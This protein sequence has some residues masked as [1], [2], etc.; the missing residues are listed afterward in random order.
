MDSIARGLQ[1]LLRKQGMWGGAGATE[2]R[3]G[4]K[5]G[6]REAC[7]GSCGS[8]ENISHSFAPRAV[9]VFTNTLRHSNTFDMPVPCL[10]HPL[11]FTRGVV[12]SSKPATN[13]KGK[14]KKVQRI[15]LIL[16]PNSSERSLICLSGLVVDVRVCP[17]RGR[18]VMDLKI[19]HLQ[20][21][22]EPALK[23]QPTS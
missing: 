13:F 15:Q 12:S 11:L 23:P 18:N 8:A 14:K 2:R 16:S 19:S 1:E 4:R 21:C 17:G 22:G 3:E 7:L 10:L 9:E 20:P 6:E 5:E